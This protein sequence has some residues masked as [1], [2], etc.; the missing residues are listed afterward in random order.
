MNITTV[1]GTVGSTLTTLSL[2]PQTIK[3]FKTG[4]VKDLS[5]LTYLVLTVGTFLWIIYGLMLSQPPI[6]VANIVTCS[7][8]LIILLMKI[9]HK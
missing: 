2:L 3:I 1:I 5:L 4:G 8:S 7:L 6:Y 9:T